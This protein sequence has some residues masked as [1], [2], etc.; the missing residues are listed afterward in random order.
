[1]LVY[2]QEV[3]LPNQLVCPTTPAEE[4]RREWYVYE[5]PDQLERAHELLRSH[6]VEIRQQYG[7]EPLLFTARDQVLRENERRTGVNPKLQ[8]KF[9]GPYKVIKA[10]SNYIYSID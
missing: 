6:Q 4:T 1:M 9:V 7:E 10:F 8:T 2:G 3:R 5:L